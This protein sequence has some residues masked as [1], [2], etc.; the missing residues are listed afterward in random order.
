MFIIR[1]SSKCGIIWLGH[2]GYVHYSGFRS[3]FKIC[4]FGGVLQWF[5]MCGPFAFFTVSPLCC[6]ANRNVCKAEAEMHARKESPHFLSEAETPTFKGKQCRNCLLFFVNIQHKMFLPLT[7][8]ERAVRRAEWRERSVPASKKAM[9]TKSKTLF[10]NCLL[11]TNKHTPPHNPAG[12]SCIFEFW[13]ILGFHP[14]CCGPLLWCVCQKDKLNT[15][16]APHSR[17][18]RQERPE[19]HWST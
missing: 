13:V 10:S 12:R 1:P 2:V 9:I 19:R 11:S 18:E 15:R 3:T 17:E 4:I 8:Y 6:K 16:G 14:V 5:V 7:E